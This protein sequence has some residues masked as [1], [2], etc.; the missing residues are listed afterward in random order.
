MDY[1]EIKC[2]HDKICIEKYGPGSRCMNNICMRPGELDNY[3]KGQ[4]PELLKL[5]SQLGPSQQ[6]EDRLE[7]LHIDLGEAIEH[8]TSGD[9]LELLKQGAIPDYQDHPDD[10]NGANEGIL[11]I[12]LYRRAQ[13]NEYKQPPKDNDYVKLDYLLQYG[14]NPDN[15][16]IGNNYKY[17]LERP[18]IEFIISNNDIEALKLF[19]K[20]DKDIIKKQNL[21]KKQL[22]DGEDTVLFSL[23]ETFDPL[24]QQ[25]LL[26]LLEKEPQIVINE[27]YDYNELGGRYFTFLEEIFVFNLTQLLNELFKYGY[28]I[29]D[30]PQ[31]K[32]QCLE[33][34]INY[35][36]RKNQIEIITLILDNVPDIHLLKDRGGSKFQ[37]YVDKER[38]KDIYEL[39]ISKKKYDGWGD[40]RWIDDLLNE[41]E[42]KFPDPYAFNFKRYSRRKS[43]KYS[44]RKSK[45]YS[46]RKSKKYSRRKY[47][48]YS[49]TKCRKK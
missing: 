15:F 26:F 6:E 7:Q 38:H 19:L 18:Y 41:S 37:D 8:S 29:N 45:K 27:F 12:L 42:S 23:R 21:I 10:Y 3:F 14:A 47:K 11:N 33:Y 35:S 44:R 30:K 32:L 49:R 46:R 43:K 13:G 36:I 31:L 1:K 24:H 4:D 9:V 48:R 2:I 28:N 40:G 5:I 34:L 25:M 20:Y 39:L 16:Q 17:L 22:T